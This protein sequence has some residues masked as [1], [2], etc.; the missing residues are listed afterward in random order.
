MLANPLVSWLP[1]SIRRR[2]LSACV[3]SCMHEGHAQ[4]HEAKEVGTWCVQVPGWR[5]RHVSPSVGRSTGMT[6]CA[7]GSPPHDYTP[8]WSPDNHTTPTPRQAPPRKHAR[9][10]GG[11]VPVDQDVAAE[12]EA[13]GAGHTGV[14]APQAIGHA[15]LVVPRLARV[16]AWVCVF[17]AR[18]M[19]LMTQAGENGRRSLF[20]A[21][22]R[23]SWTHGRGGMMT[24]TATARQYRHGSPHHPT[25]GTCVR[26][27]HRS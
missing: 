25:R 1:S 4:R 3:C 14:L 15:Q 11:E 18:R 19:G 21:Q 5:M 22:L 20:K 16:C 13:C 7:V 17:E 24:H 9:T 8:I 12:A 23:P 26:L 6:E 27:A 10:L 2:M